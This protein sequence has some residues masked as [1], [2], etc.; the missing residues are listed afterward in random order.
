M[1]KF[2]EESHN[3]PM[4]MSVKCPA[5]GA[6]RA[7]SLGALSLAS[8]GPRTLLERTVLVANTLLFMTGCATVGVEQQRLVSK[9]NMQFSE[10]RAFGDPTR[11]A[12]QLEPGRVVTGGA[13][14]SV[15]TSC[16]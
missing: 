5:C 10:V 6:G 12:S 4:L 2:E 1:C 3:A 9:P 11:I 7:T 13:Q 16:R 15:C 14:S 8:C